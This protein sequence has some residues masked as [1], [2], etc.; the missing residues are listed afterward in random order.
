[1]AD[2]FLQSGDF[3]WNSGMFFWSLTTIMKAF[4]KYLPEV[5]Q[6]F[7][8]GKAFYNTEQEADFIS[9]VYPNCKNISIDYGSE[10]GE[11]IEEPLVGR[12]EAPRR[13]LRGGD[14]RRGKSGTVGGRAQRGAGRGPGQAPAAAQASSSHRT[15]LSSPTTTSS[16]AHRSRGGAHRRVELSRARRRRDPP[17]DLALVSVIESGLPD[18]ELGDSAACAPASS[19]S[20][21]ATPSGFSPPSPAAS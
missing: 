17:T 8:E 5:D 20:P 21:S 12:C 6:L 2:V 13:V 3:F 15:A 14:R 16:K 18:A 10:T 1:M 4:N 11:R 9:K 19:S 7:S